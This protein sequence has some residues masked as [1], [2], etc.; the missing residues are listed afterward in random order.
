MSRYLVLYTGTA[1]SMSYDIMTV[2]NI[3]AKRHKFDCKLLQKSN[4]FP[5]GTM[6]YVEKGLNKMDSSNNNSKLLCN[7]CDSPLQHK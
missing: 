1:V 3:L 7:I 4:I 5:S 6:A 2:Y